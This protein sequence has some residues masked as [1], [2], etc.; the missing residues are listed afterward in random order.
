MKLI[1]A[2]LASAKR[3]EAELI[4]DH[5]EAVARRGPVNEGTEQKKYGGS[6]P[7]ERTRTGFPGGRFPRGTFRFLEG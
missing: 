1:A 2:E 6:W 4:A 5:G 7:G 3:S